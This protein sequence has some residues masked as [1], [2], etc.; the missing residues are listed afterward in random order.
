[1]QRY[2]CQRYGMKRGITVI[3]P[4]PTPVYDPLEVW[5]VLG[6]Q[7]ITAVQSH[8]KRIGG[9]EGWE[10]K[11]GRD[12][13]FRN[14]NANVKNS[15]PKW[16]Y[17]AS[18]IEIR[19]WESVKKTGGEGEFQRKKYKRHKCDLKKNLC[20]RFHPSWTKVKCSNLWGKLTNFF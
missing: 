7:F 9:K 5:L 3:T 15:I 13:G 11:G 12:G 17:V 18:F 10:F 4:E 16:I 2:L 14:K 1:M 6:N 20:R 19:Q 8:G